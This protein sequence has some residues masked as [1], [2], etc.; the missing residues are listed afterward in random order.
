MILFEK[1]RKLNSRKDK[2]KNNKRIHTTHYLPVH[3]KQRKHHQNK[4]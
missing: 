1:N 4:V 2:E 3:I